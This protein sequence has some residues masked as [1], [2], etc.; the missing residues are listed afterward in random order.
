MGAQ[1]LGAL[2][3]PQQSARHTAAQVVAAVAVIEL[4]Q[5]Q[6]AELIQGLVNNVTTT[7]NDF[8]KQSS[9]EALGF[10]CEEIVRS[11]RAL[12]P[13]RKRPASARSV[14]G[15]CSC[16]CAESARPDLRRIRRRWSGNLI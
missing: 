6:W 7:Q 5:G 3:S 16:A 2:A 8:L 15:D 10:I 12:S 4:P 13:T 9:L 14:R 11:S 1:V